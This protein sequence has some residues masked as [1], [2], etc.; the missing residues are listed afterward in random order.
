MPAPCLPTPDP[1]VPTP[2]PC[3]PVAARCVRQ[4]ED[5]AVRIAIHLSN[6]AGDAV[7]KD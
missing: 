1:C 6:V 5:R 7:A 3:V 2:D 4:L